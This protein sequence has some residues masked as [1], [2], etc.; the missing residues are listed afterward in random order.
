LLVLE[1]VEPRL[2]AIALDGCCGIEAVGIV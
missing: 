1:V 2:R